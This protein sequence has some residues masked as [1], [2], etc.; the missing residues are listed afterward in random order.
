MYALPQIHDPQ[1]EDLVGQ[2]HPA[3]PASISPQ[4]QLSKL[5][6][7]NMLIAI[8]IAEPP[9][10]LCLRL[11]NNESHSP[12]NPAPPAQPKSAASSLPSPASP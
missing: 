10:I 1:A 9:S 2:G 4:S 6:E 11:K 7:P 8:S 12:R 5:G 3:E